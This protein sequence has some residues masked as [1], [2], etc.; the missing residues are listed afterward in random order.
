[1]AVHAYYPDYRHGQMPP[2]GIDQ[3]VVGCVR[4]FSLT[5]KPDGRLAG[6]TPARMRELT[7]VAACSVLVIGGA[8]RSSNFRSARLDALV[9]S[10]VAAVEQY[11]D[12]GV[13]IDWEQLD[14]VDHGGSRISSNVSAQRSRAG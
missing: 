5:P 1:V 6:M 4:H 10:I 7:S 2:Q 11:G 8:G 9:A 3:S 13:G 14:N 12:D